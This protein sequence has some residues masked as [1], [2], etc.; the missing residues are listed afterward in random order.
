MVDAWYTPAPTG[1]RLRLLTSF[2]NVTEEY[3]TPKL[4]E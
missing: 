2:M 3:S 4:E 1:T